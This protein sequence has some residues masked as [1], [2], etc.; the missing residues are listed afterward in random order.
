M[1]AAS[2]SN[3]PA[4]RKLWSDEVLAVLHVAQRFIEGHHTFLVELG[5]TFERKGLDELLPAAAT[6]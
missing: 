2:G 4:S 3:A 6:S 5:L 1:P